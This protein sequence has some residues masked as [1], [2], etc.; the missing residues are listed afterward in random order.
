MMSQ[1]VAS[2]YTTTGGGV[3]GGG[4]HPRVVAATVGALRVVE[5][6]LDQLPSSADDALP[7]AGSVVLR[8]LTYD[9]QRAVQ[10]PE[11]DLGAG[12]H[13]QAPIFHA[14]QGAIT[15]LRLI[16]QARQR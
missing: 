14:A 8:A 3:I 2:L 12:R 10:A 1:D 15:G 6:Q 11:R 16:D 7:P 9:G 5:A 4:E 13:P